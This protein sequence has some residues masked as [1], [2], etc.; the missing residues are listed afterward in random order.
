M[1]IIPV[2]QYHV[3]NSTAPQKKLGELPHRKKR[4]RKNTKSQGETSFVID[5]PSSHHLK[6]AG[7]N[8]LISGQSNAIGD[9]VTTNDHV[10]SSKKKTFSSTATANHPPNR[11]NYRSLIGKKTPDSNARDRIAAARPYI[12]KAVFCIN[13][14]SVQTEEFDLVDYIKKIGIDVLSCHQ[15]MPCRSQWQR[16]QKIVPSYRRAFRV[17]IPRED[18]SRFLDADSWPAHIA[19]TP[20]HFVKPKQDNRG[21]RD[22][23]TL[24]DAGLTK[25]PV[26][27][28]SSPSDSLEIN[29][30]SS[31]HQ[32]MDGLPSEFRGPIDSVS[33]DALEKG[34]SSVPEPICTVRLQSTNAGNTE[35]RT[36]K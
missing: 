22:P 33:Q 20:W 12:G 21:D 23:G 2:Q 34:I 1:T 6:L 32:P 5:Q 8:E 35:D 31:F 7:N 27:I 16:Q 13:N 4:K 28:S 19:I 36:S 29:R 15:V 30:H 9:V 14:V 26:M 18:T 24:I 10:N 17:C 3:M 11:V 25:S